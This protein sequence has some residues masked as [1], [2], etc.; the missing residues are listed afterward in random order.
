[1]TDYVNFVN[2]DDYEEAND[3]KP[4]KS[5]ALMNTLY[6][7]DGKP[8]VFDHQTMEYYRTM[9]KL[10]MDPIIL[11]TVPDEFSFKYSY[12]W[13]PVSGEKLD[14]DPYGPLCFH[15]DIL[16]KHFYV[17]R[18]ND[19]WTPDSQDGFQGIYGDAVGAG[20]DIYIQSRGYHP[21]KYL[22][23]LPIIDCYWADENPNKTII[24]YGPKL[25]DD[26]VKLIDSLAAKSRS[27]PYPTRPSLATIKRLYDNA[28]SKTPIVP[29]FDLTNM[30]YAEKQE[31]YNAEN[32][33]CV[34][35]LKK[36]KG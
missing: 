8:V 20:E 4:A 32:R 13:D 24:T 33:R 19:I 16:I 6:V 26:E 31:R 18:L 14:V 12:Q 29:G 10:K 21:E 11:D 25:T 3:Q 7:R 35:Q 2:F 5:E 1:M 22:F 9:R 36:M 17:N 15:P 27:Y 30:T 28:L 34:D 23:R